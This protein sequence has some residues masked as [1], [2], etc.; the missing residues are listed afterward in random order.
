[1]QTT[2]SRKANSYPDR[3]ACETLFDEYRMPENV[4]EHTRQVA[5][6]AVYLANAL[7]RSGEI[8]DVG[9]VESASLLHDIARAVEFSDDPLWPLLKA[10]YGETDHKLLG[11]KIME[12][13]PGL[14]TII[15]K[16]GY[17]SV[18]TDPPVTWEEKI[19]NY[20]DKRIAH[21]GIVSLD[22]RFSEGRRRWL[23]RDK[24]LDSKMEA[25]IVRKH[26]EIESEIFSKIGIM[27]EQLKEELNH[28]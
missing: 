10:R 27:S 20:A 3:K 26:K 28:A 5:K 16:H 23:K 7:R 12:K 8:V 15:R 22:E 18:I 24:P 25:E 4:R 21:T 1:M 2:K 13:Y 14:S 11:A 19:V 6:V 9:L 17:A